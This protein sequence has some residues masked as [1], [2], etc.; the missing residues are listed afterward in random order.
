MSDA[1][2]RTEP[3]HAEVLGILAS[4]FPLTLD[5]LDR[6]LLELGGS[7]AEGFV[8]TANGKA[9]VKALEEE[10]KG[11]FSQ[12]ISAA[13]TAIA[14]ALKNVTPEAVDAT[15]KSV[16]KKIIAGDFAGALD[17][18]IAQAVAEHRK[19]A[20]DA[21]V[22][23]VEKHFDI[24]GLVDAAAAPKTAE[25][26]NLIATGIETAFIFASP[27]PEDGIF[28]AAGQDITV[29]VT[30]AVKE[31]ADKFEEAL[32]QDP[33]T[34]F[35]TLVEV[36]ITAVKSS[37]KGQGDFISQLK[38]DSTVKALFGKS[39]DSEEIMEE[40]E[41]ADEELAEYERQLVLIDEGG[42]AAADLK[43]IEKLMA[44]MQK[45]QQTI[46]LVLM[47]GEAVTG[48]GTS[49][50]SLANWARNDFTDVVVGEILGP[51]KAAKLILKLA[52]NL[53]KAAE[54]I[55]L[56]NTFV[57]NN[58]RAMKAAS[59][60]TSAIS[61]FSERKSTQIAF[62]TIE[63]ALLIVEIASTILGSVPEPFTMAIGKTMGLVTKAAQGVSEGAEFLF[64]EKKLAEAWKTTI[65]AL[66]D[67]RNR[68]LGLSALR[69]NPTLAMHA[70]AWAAMTKQPPDPIARI[71][72]SDLGLN[73]Q[74]LAVSG[75]ER[76]VR[77]YLAIKLSEDGEMIDPDLVAPEWA[78]KSV[79]LNR[80]DW[81]LV[82]L[83][84]KREA[85]PKLTETT[86][87][88]ILKALEPLESHTVDTW[89][90]DA[91]LGNVPPAV[92][93]KALAE[94]LNLR[95]LLRAYSPT[96]RDGGTHEDMD[97]LGIMFS[98]QAN[99]YA[100]RLQE[101]VDHNR[102]KRAANIQFT[103]EDIEKQ[104]EILNNCRAET[105][106]DTIDKAIED[107]GVLVLLV[108]ANRLDTQEPI[109]KLYE[110]LA[111]EVKELKSDLNAMREWNNLAPSFRS[112]INST[113]DVLKKELN[114]DLPQLEQTIKNYQE[115]FDALK[116]DPNMLDKVD[117]AFTELD[118]VISK[119]ISENKAIPAL[120]LYLAR[121][122]KAAQ[123]EQR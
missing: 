103:K 4:G 12:V 63:D 55:R 9:L 99:D 11:A 118:Q 58:K 95:N 84:A 25:L 88:A 10:P 44:E 86:E 65:A 29:S 91:E 3:D 45:D 38:E 98:K 47:V 61:G 102:Q 54:R 41:K 34:A 117:E 80:E 36:V 30:K 77:E 52:V 64:T 79:K 97:S 62:R 16:L 106:L 19:E 109:T 14:S 20:G 37:I 100:T 75:S 94:A 93:E 87:A 116:T 17:A 40:L 53:K 67:T 60:L 22:G 96:S 23:L 46:E 78:P 121:M 122:R 82:T 48:F 81:Y 89:A 1:V 50:V 24:I 6:A 8:K 108:Q 31:N 105:S 43:S 83:R 113:W 68:A 101:I 18:R 107:A 32:A 5:E 110:S 59:S 49:G 69:L 72:L 76:K 119:T 85:V 115:K 27:N 21:F 57:A 73:E 35:R 71:A 114:L 28:R 123:A 104:L 42:I 15:N 112:G 92:L 111:A 33:N 74:T 51:L 26:G 66:N 7:I 13:D 2:A 120:R 56:F 70:I 39:V 90:K